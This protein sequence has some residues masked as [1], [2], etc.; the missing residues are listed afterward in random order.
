MHHIA[1]LIM[2]VL[3]AGSLMVTGLSGC[4]DEER[5]RATAYSSGFVTGEQVTPSASDTFMK[6]AVDINTALLNVDAKLQAAQQAQSQKSQEEIDKLEAERRALMTK[7]DEM[8]SAIE[9]R[10]NALKQQGQVLEDQY[11]TLLQTLR[12]TGTTMTPASQS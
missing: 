1:L 7:R 9:A 8:V 10:Q 3:V 2:P 4:S 11:Q 6:A 5:A 12:T